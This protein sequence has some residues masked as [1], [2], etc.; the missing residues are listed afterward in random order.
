M[1]IVT[2]VGARPQFIKAAVVSRVFVDSEDV[3]EII[4]HT[5]QHF[6]ANMSDVFFE[7][8]CIPKPHYN[9]NINGLGHG[10]MT[11]QMLEK[12]EEVLL[13]EK[14]NWVLVYGDTNST[15]AGALAAKKL[16]IK[17]AHVEAG[18]RSFNMNMPEEVNRI[19]TDRIS[20][21]LF[22]PTEKAVENLNNEGYANIKCKIVRNGDVMQDAA[23]FYSDKCRKP[24][25]DL[26]SFVLCTVH[27]AENTD[28]PRR[29]KNIFA[30][31]ESIS[32]QCKVVL[33]LHPRTKGKLNDIGYDFAHSNIRFIQ[34]V[35]YLEMV[36]LLKNCELVM[37]DSGGLQKEA[38]F[39]SKYCIT[40]RDETEWI[41]LVDN[42]FNRLVGSNPTV[43]EETYTL[44]M[45]I[46]KV[47]FEKKLYGNGD[48]GNKI[49]YALQRDDSL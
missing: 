41:E 1:K 14:P 25:M 16:H 13:K 39:F 10:A 28:D 29:L 7:E 19:L 5:G 35:G 15:I 23:L 32:K 46:S 34:P 30:A 18:L 4:V 42:G 31:L 47:G 49:L 37:T 8:M 2:I 24:V 17:V 33:P 20:D 44:L 21:I 22:C 48:A 12:I 36:W 26:S 43:I 40:M 11:G 9:L 38:Y 6:D 27:R 45:N 3:E